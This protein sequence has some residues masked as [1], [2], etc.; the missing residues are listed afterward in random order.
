MKF[1]ICDDEP[2]CVKM[3]DDYIKTRKGFDIKTMIFYSGEALLA[4]CQEEGQSFDAFFIDIEMSGMDGVKTAKAIREMDRDV[5]IIFVTSYKKYAIDCINCGPLRFLVKPIQLDALKEAV[6][7]II[8]LIT[9][10]RETISFKENGDDVRLYCDEI[11]FCE[12]NGHMLTLY[13]K[14]GQFRTRINISEL[15]EHLKKAHFFRP[16]KS[17]L[18]NMRYLKRICDKD[19]ELYGTSLRIPL[20]RNKKSALQEA[21]VAEMERRYVV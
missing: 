2:S 10:K 18:I 6:D 21:F 1:A 7:S 17:Y 16:H 4:Q 3:I 20:S 5:S 13:T 11:I 19:V 14:E 15:E 12:S 8:K 9:E